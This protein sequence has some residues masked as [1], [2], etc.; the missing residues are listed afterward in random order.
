MATHPVFLSGESHGDR[1]LEGYSPLGHKRFRHYLVMKPANIM[2]LARLHV[3]IQA[4]GLTP[5]NAL[6]SL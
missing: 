5:R 3:N 2:S 1:S 6:L 4:H